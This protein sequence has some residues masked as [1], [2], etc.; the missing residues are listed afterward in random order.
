MSQCQAVKINCRNTIATRR[1]LVSREVVASA[2]AMSRRMINTINASKILNRRR[3]SLLIA[4]VDFGNHGD[5]YIVC[6]HFKMPNSIKAFA[7]FRRIIRS[8][9]SYERRH[10][11]RIRNCHPYV[12]AEHAKLLRL[13][14]SN[15]LSKQH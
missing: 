14:A 12:S 13:L 4:W 3:G 8:M 6:V 10:E 7:T 9:Q 11:K 2:A 15:D 1:F 5:N